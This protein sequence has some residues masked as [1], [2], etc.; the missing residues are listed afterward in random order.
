MSN[1]DFNQ[2]SIIGNSHHEIRNNFEDD[3]LEIIRKFNSN[4]CEYNLNKLYHEEF[5]RVVNMFPNHKAIVYDNKDITYSE[6]NKMCNSLANYLRSIGVKRNSIIPI[7]CGRSFYFIIAAVSVMKA[8]GAFVYIETEYP[9]S[10]K[11]FIIDEVKASII[12]V[13]KFNFENR[14][15]FKKSNKHMEIVNIEE[16]NYNN[17][18]EEISNINESKDYCFLTY[19]SGSSGL[20]KG[21]VIS[22]INLIHFCLYAQT[23]NG[24]KD[25]FINYNNVIAYTKFNYIMSIAELF[26]PLLHNKKIVLCNDIEY[27]NSEALGN[28][29]TKY[30][31]DFMVGTPTRIKNYMENNIFKK[32]LMNI[33]YFGFGGEIVTLDF[34][35][36]ISR[37]TN[38]ELY[39]GYGATETTS[40]I[41]FYKITDINIINESYSFVGKPNCNCKVYILDDNLNP[42]PIGKRGTIFISGNCIS[43]GY[44]N[45]EEMTRKKFIKCPLYHSIDNNIMY[46]TGDV[47]EWN[48]DGNI[49]YYGREDLQIKIRGQRIEINEIESAINTIKDIS[50]TCVNSLNHEGNNILICYFRTKNNDINEEY[51]KEYLIDILPLYMVPVFYIRIQNIPLNLNGKLDRRNNE[52]DKKSEKIDGNNGIIMKDLDK[53]TN[54]KINDYVRLHGISKTAFFI[55]LYGFILSKYCNQDSIY[56]SLI[57]NNRN[58][59]YTEKLIGM[60]VSTQPILLNYEN[61]DETFLNLIKENTNLL[62][63]IYD[64]QDVSFSELKRELKLKNLN[65]AFVFQS[66]IIFE[67]GNNN[68]IF[69]KE[70]INEIY[71]IYENSNTESNTN[72][73]VVQENSY[74]F[75]I[76]FNVVENQENYLISVNYNESILDSSMMK[77]MIDSYI[78]V[79]KSL[80]DYE[81][82]NI[83]ELEYI[84]SEEKEK[85]L[86]AFNSNQYEYESDKL[87][88]TEFSRVAQQ[89]PDAIAIVCNDK[90]ISYRE[91][92]EKSNSLAHFL[93]N[94]GIGR[95]DI[96]PIIS[97]RSYYFVIAILGVMKS[98][99]AYLPVDPEFPISRIKYM[100]IQTDEVREYSLSLHDY[101][102]NTQEISNINESSDTCYILFT[103]GTTGKPNQSTCGK[104]EYYGNDMNSVLAICKFTHDISI[105]EINYPLLKACKIILCNDKEY[106]DPYL[107]GNLIVKYNINYIFTVPSRFNNYLYQ[108]NFAKSIRNVKHILLG[109]EKV[110]YKTVMDIQKISNSNV[111]SVYGPSETSVVSNVKL[112][113]TFQNRNGINNKIITVGKPLCNFEIYILDKYMKVVPIGVKGEIYISG[114][115]VGKGYLNQKELTEEKYIECP[116]KSKEGRVKS[117]KMFKTGD[118]GKWNKEGEVICLGRND[119]QIKIRGQRLKIQEIEN[120]IKEIKAIEYVVVIVKEKQNGE[121][122]LIA[123]YMS[124]GE[125]DL[126]NEIKTYL[127][128]K[129]PLYMVPSFYIRI[130]EIPVTVNGKLNKKEL[131]EPNL[132]E[133]LKEEYQAPE[134]LVEKKICSIYAK[135]FQLNEDEVGISHDFYS[136]GGDSLNTIRVISEIK[137]AFK[138]NISINDIIKNNKIKD[139]VN[140]IKNKIAN[141]QKSSIKEDIK[142]EEIDEYPI[143]SI[144]SFLGVD[145]IDEEVKFIDQKYYSS[146]MWQLFEIKLN[147]INLKKLEQ[148]FNVIINRHKVL[149]TNF[150]KK[151]KEGKTIIIGK[152]NNNVKLNFEYYSKENFNTFLKP[153]NYNDGLLIRVGLIENSVLMI[154]IDHRIA[155]GYSYGIL[156]NELTKVYNDQ[157]LT[158]LPIQYTDFAIYYDKLI[159][160]NNFSK[161]LNYYKSIFDKEI[162]NINLPV[163]SIKRTTVENKIKLK[164]IIINTNIETYN[165]VNKITKENSLSKT[166]FFLIAYS[167]V[168]S[169]YSGQNSIYT[170]II[171][172]NRENSFTDKIIGMFAKYIPILIHF[173]DQNIINLIKNYMEIIYTVFSYDIPLFKVKEGLNI[174]NCNSMFKFDP[175]KMMNT[176]EIGILNLIRSNTIDGEEIREIKNEISS[177]VDLIFVITEKKNSYEIFFEYNELIYD[178]NLIESIVNSFISVISNENFADLTI[179]DIKN[180]SIIF[181]NY[182][183]FNDSNRN[184]IYND[185]NIEYDNII[186][187]DI[188]NHIKNINDNDDKIKYTKQSIRRIN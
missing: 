34:L 60:F 162:Q 73:I 156:I 150:I 164:R 188:K 52:D 97:E 93:R 19:T 14:I 132:D 75:D 176:D 126:S 102:M 80:E 56:S 62:M 113:D 16:H 173:E 160:S 148:S 81:K 183:T 174:P 153:F 103:S 115:G 170:N 143:T 54:Q 55:T 79:I 12:L 36:D 177:L 84:P 99:A 157:K 179:N 139:I 48:N 181:N 15:L 22:H 140:L 57:S 61:A 47:G 152:I 121:K 175:Y 21:V 4:K 133:L 24:V 5:K 66:R 137:E 111:Y 72:G 91:L 82:V 166:V 110:D 28:L 38:A 163:K 105:G 87:Y 86:R 125:E 77:K 138:I 155:D 67:N 37:V 49:K 10:R 168:I 129:L 13:D 165:N 41:C 135:I 7:M 159:K 131:P 9:N 89:N 27:N 96:V 76:T 158:D 45:N 182:L 74:K 11:Q 39:C 46:N 70:N 172:S 8:G 26:Y 85:I 1:K 63:D 114:K 161:E 78:E 106:N 185:K 120:V 154:D 64:K 2:F 108:E 58:N 59:Y 83:T 25:Y 128:M 51:I 127:K 30:K 71:T 180:N 65:N 118:L 145:L 32:S 88:H 95:G 42:L 136:L 68:T 18:T 29:I 134:T 117:K 17:N 149:K 186:N 141:D 178:N 6:L 92:D 98:G 50:F 23:Y 142:I 40:M 123:Y 69:K 94:A 53:E 147:N 122:Y 101:D 146:H 112:L 167:L 144:V 124:N 44:F 184:N 171:Y 43:Q 20:P 130:K 3:P 31:I 33:K 35:K 187:N 119:N 116:F 104:N 90:K 151:T 109:G 169:L 107:I 100:K